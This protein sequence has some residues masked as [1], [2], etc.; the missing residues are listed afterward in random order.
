MKKITLLTS[1][2]MMIAVLTIII[3]FTSCKKESRALN[4]SIA[5]ANSNIASAQRQTAQL[6]VDVEDFSFFIENANM[7]PAVGDN[8]LLWDKFGHVP[9]LAPDGHQITLGEFNSVTG[10]AQ[11][12][13][14]N[15]GTHVVIHLKNLIPNGVYTIWT[16]TFKSPGW[17]GTFDNEIGEG[18]L[19]AP[20]GSQNAFT[21]S[22]AGT[23][24]LSVIIPAGPLSEFG[25][26][27]N[28]LSSEYEVHLGAAYHLVN[29]T[30]GGVPGDLNAFV[31][32]FV[33]PFHGSQ[34]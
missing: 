17:D 14:I 24:S 10:Y 33:F 21:A 4:S 34:L 6:T 16:E 18:A 28:C 5:S 15:A 19:G 32:Q 26:V 7:L 9:I 29:I 22:P 25:S 1:T 11:V 20:D 30:H 8:T 12:S 2:V 3:S 31:V 13:C 27:G 23:A